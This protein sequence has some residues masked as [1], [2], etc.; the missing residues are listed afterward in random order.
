MPVL[1]RL[2]ANPLGSP[3]APEMMFGVLVVP[4]VPVR[5]RVLLPEPVKVIA[6]AMVRTAPPVPEASIVAP[7]VV[8]TRS[9]TRSV[10]SFAEPVHLRV[11]VFATSP[12]AMVPSPAVVGAPRPPATLTLPMF[13]TLR[14]PFLMKVCPV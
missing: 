12:M 3:M 5:V 1:S 7:P 9:M 10:D 14:V 4:P 11:P 6:V 2:V 8:P 13:D